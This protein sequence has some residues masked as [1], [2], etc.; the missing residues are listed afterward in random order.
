MRDAELIQEAS[1][2]DRSDGAHH[3]EP[4][5]CTGQ[6]QEALGSALRLSRLDDH[7]PQ[8][9]LE[10]AAEIG[11]MDVASLTR[12]QHPAELLLELANRARQRGLGDA[13]GG[14]GFGEVARLTDRQK[15]ADL[16]KFHFPDLP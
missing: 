6:A 5:R 7:L 3:P 4:D 15:V 14:C 13:A 2:P 1:E 12:H 11:E 9:R 16:V 10:E 8:A